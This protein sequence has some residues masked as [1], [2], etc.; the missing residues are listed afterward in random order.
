[1]INYQ[2]YP[3]TSKLPKFLKTTIEEVF[4]KNADIIDSSTNEYHSNDVLELLRK[5]F[6]H[7]NFQV[8]KSKLAKDKIK[9]D[10]IFSSYR[11]SS[12]LKGVLLIGY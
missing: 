12:A 10:T 2:Y 8:E 5:D 11:F 9:I 6:E 1:M 3:K 4:K 7:L